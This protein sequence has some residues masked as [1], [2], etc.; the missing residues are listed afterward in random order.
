VRPSP[1]ATLPSDRP[2]G[3]P[4]GGKAVARVSARP[5]PTPR[6]DPREVADRRKRQVAAATIVAFGTLWGLVAGHQVSKASAASLPPPTD[7][8]P[9]PISVPAQPAPAQPA[10]VVDPF[11]GQGPEL[12]MG[13]GPPILRSGGS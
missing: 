5:N 2:A 9:A 11:A 1:R 3:L 12:Q 4:S 13:W 8:T 6:P 10:P 7:G